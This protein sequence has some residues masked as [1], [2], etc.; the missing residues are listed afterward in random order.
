M[1]CNIIFIAKMSSLPPLSTY[2]HK[3]LANG[4]ANPKYIDL[5]NEDPPIA[6]QKFGCFSFISPEDIIK[7]REIFYFEEFVKQWDFTKSMTKSTEFLNF[8]SYKYNLQFESLIQDFEEF[9]KE[10]KERLKADSVLDDYKTF[11]D[12]NEPNLLEEYQKQNGF[13]TSVRGFMSRGHF[14][15]LEE[16]EHHAKRIRKTDPNHDIF[17]GT[18]GM[19]NIFHPDA[20]KTGGRIEYLEDELNQLHHEKLKNETLKNEAFQQRVLETKRNAIRENIELAK[21]SGNVLTQTISESG[22]LIGVKQL[23]NFDEREAAPEKNEK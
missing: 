11:L 22:E 20:Y 14:N 13:R 3:T 23:V 6:G 5:L 2:E 21:K 19:W 16:A 15:S 7:S 10:E 8:V 1:I 9:V 4:T 17:I 12:K 18:V